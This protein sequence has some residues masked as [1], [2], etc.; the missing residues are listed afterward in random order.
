MTRIKKL[1]VV[2]ALV[3]IASLSVASVVSADTEDAPKTLKAHGDGLAALH[4]SGRVRVRGNG[5]LWVKGAETIRVQ[6]KGRQK[7]FPSGWTEYVGFHGA[8]YIEGRGVSVILAGERVD[9]HAVGNG[10]AFL[11]GEG[12]YE[13]GDLTSAAWSDDIKII[14][15]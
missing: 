8:A 11:W 5:I 3:I 7:T 9:L 4:G 14:S 2:L 1:S 15:Y 12:R 6:G 13:V 10:R